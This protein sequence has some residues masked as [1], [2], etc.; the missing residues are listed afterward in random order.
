[1][2][3]GQGLRRA[4]LATLETNTWNGGQWRGGPKWTLTGKELIAFYRAIETDNLMP[5]AVLGCETMSDRKVDRAVQLLKK[6]KLIE[7]DRETRRWKP[8]DRVLSTEA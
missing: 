3:M 4:I 7:F 6:N 1:M 5:Y 8:T 2:L